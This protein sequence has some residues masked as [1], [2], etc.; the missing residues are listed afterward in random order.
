ME[1]NVVLGFVRLFVA[2]AFNVAVVGGVF[3]A[4]KKIKSV[5]YNNSTDHFFN[6]VKSIKNAQLN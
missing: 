5:H 4:V 6:G 3:N 1:T 2:I